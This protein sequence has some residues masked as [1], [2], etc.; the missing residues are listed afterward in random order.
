MRT[1]SPRSAPALAVA[2][3]ALAVLAAAPPAAAEEDIIGAEE[4]RLSCAPCHGAGGRGDGPVAQYLNTE[5][6]DLT[7]LAEANGGQFPIYDVIRMIDGRMMMEA[8]GDRAMPI[9]GDRYD[10]EIPA[11]AHPQE[12][13]FRDQLVHGRILQLVNYLQAIQQPEGSM[14]RLLGP[15]EE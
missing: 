4:Y 1:L 5:P 10:A 11:G 3:T 2:A 7:G 8:H 13:V 15:A 9:W 12:A 6:G 14:E